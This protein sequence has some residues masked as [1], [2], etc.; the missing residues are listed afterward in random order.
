[1]ITQ[2]KE[3]SIYRGLEQG[4]VERQH[5][6][7]AHHE[8]A[9]EHLGTEKHKVLDKGAARSQG[10][11]KNPSPVQREIAEPGN[12]TGSGGSGKY[13]FHGN[14]AKKGQGQAEYQQVQRGAQKRGTAEFQEFKTDFDRIN[15]GAEM[16]RTVSVQ[17]H[18]SDR[19]LDNRKFFCC[20]QQ[21]VK[22]IFKALSRN[23]EAFYNK[24]FWYA[25]E[26]GLGVGTGYAGNR[27]EKD[28]RDLVSPSAFERNARIAEIPDP[29]TRLVGFASKVLDVRE[30]SSGR[31]WKSASAVTKLLPG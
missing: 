29:S 20:G 30:I 22:F 16:S 31:C 6:K 4:D 3:A 21:Q 14:S 5:R 11:G 24:T 17:V 1:M 8:P 26:P 28:P 25:P 12:N 15:E 19:N 13:P 10:A 7:E 23:A 27:A 9:C 2:H 18:G